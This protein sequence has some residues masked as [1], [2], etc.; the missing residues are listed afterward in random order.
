VKGVHKCLQRKEKYEEK[1]KT[2]FKFLLIF[3]TM[4]NGYF[5]MPMGCSKKHGV[6]RSNGPQ[7]FIV[8]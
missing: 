8:I 6:R 4:V 7:G 2:Y 1:D 3:S 5:S